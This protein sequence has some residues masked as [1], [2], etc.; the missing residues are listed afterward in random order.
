MR[1]ARDIISWILIIAGIAILLFA[2]LWWTLA[3]K[4]LILYPSG[5]DLSVACEG[6]I[7]Q[8]TGKHGLDALSHPRKEDLELSV[9]L[10]S[11]DDEYTS[12][13]AVL[14]QETTQLST[15][16]L[17]LEMGAINMLGMRFNLVNIAG[18]PIILGIGVDFGVYILHR[19]KEEHEGEGAT[20][21]AVLAHTG[22]AIVISGL[23]V[24]AAFSALIFARYQG[25]ASLGI[26]A[27]VGIA[28]AAISA[29]TVLPAILRLLERYRKKGRAF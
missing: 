23:A 18:A 28:F 21:P 6:T 15:A 4:R 3:V 10:T 5:V 24:I 7:D 2:M 17:G 12:Q 9:K 14:D 16:D 13:A 20:I 29:V 25:L 8:L 1:S 22:R 27:A 11:V 26:V 19:Y